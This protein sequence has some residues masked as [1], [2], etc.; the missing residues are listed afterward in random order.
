MLFI[1]S[2]EKP[3]LLDVV[4]VLMAVIGAFFLSTGGKFI[5]QPGDALEALGALFW[6]VHFVILGK[7][8]SRFE[9]LSFSVGQSLVGGLLNLI[10]GLF[11]ENTHS[12]LIGPV[13]VAVFYRA[14]FS[15]GIGYTMQVWGQK[16]TPPTDAALILSLEAVFGALAAWYILNQSLL[17]V[18]ILG[19]IIIFSA[20]VISQLKI[21]LIQTVPHV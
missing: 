17:P 20:V 9:P 5:F 4:S 13:L 11:V 3:H 7:F 15:V 2:R 12:L 8:A 16:H 1:F 21:F 14:I 19:C 6:G 18:Q 10:I